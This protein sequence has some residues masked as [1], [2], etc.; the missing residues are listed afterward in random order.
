MLFHAIQGAGGVGGE[1]EF[2]G[3]QYNVTNEGTSGSTETFG[4]WTNGSYSSLEPGDLVIVVWQVPS[5]S[6]RNFNVSGWTEIAD[7]YANDS[8][9]AQIAAFYKVMGDPADTSFT[10]SDGYAA[11]T[12]IVSIA[13]R[14]VD[15]STPLDVSAV[16]GTI[17][18]TNTVNFDP[19]TPVTSGAWIVAMA[20]STQPGD[21]RPEMGVD[22]HTL[23]SGEFDD[24]VTTWTATGD[25]DPDGDFVGADGDDG[26]TCTV[27]W[28]SDWVSGAFDPTSW[29]APY[30]FTTSSAAYILLALR[31]A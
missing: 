4:T 9:D 13:F 19:I 16:T 17:T 7:L 29:T 22:F 26:T 28:K 21:G 5:T 6:D 14:G 11:S 23:G 2:V 27:A 25:N 30:D 20:S 24:S 10:W 3:W 31:P 8:T 15:T 1:I 12:S 18:N